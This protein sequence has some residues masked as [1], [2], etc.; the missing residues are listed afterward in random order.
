MGAYLVDYVIVEVKG[1][2]EYGKLYTCAGCTHLEKGTKV[3]CSDDALGVVEGIVVSSYTT[4]SDNIDLYQFLTD[5]FGSI[6]GRVVAKIE[7]KEINYDDE[8]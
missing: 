3:E 5:A 2:E 6:D 4:M 1:F 8:F 7:R